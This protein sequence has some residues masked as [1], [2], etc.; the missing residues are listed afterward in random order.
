MSFLLMM[1]QDAANKVKSSTSGAFP[2]RKS[3]MPRKMTA[4]MPLKGLSSRANISGFKNNQ[5]PNMGNRYGSFQAFRFT[6][7]KSKLV[8]NF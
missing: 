7:V 6:G 3:T 5:R 8:V 1:F 4:D 2:I